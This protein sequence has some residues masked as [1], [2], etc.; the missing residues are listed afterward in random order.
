MGHLS[1]L[2]DSLRFEPYSGSLEK[3]VALLKNARYNFIIN[4]L[5]ICEAFIINLPNSLCEKE[6]NCDFNKDSLIQINLFKIGNSEIEKEYQDR[7][8]VMRSKNTPFA[9]IF[10]KVR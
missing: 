10:L 7:L 5:D 4:P 1:L 9:T 6:E 2:N 3:G 8:L